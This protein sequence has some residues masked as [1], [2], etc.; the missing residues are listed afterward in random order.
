MVRSH[1]HELFAGPRPRTTCDRCHAQ[2]LRCVKSDDQPACL[3]C[4]KHSTS[5]TFSV[6]TKRKTRDAKSALTGTTSPMPSPSPLL[7]QGSELSL[8]DLPGM[9]LSLGQ[10][11]WAMDLGNLFAA[12][13]LDHMS[14]GSSIEA[15]N[16]QCSATL[17]IVRE[18]GTMNVRLYDH[19]CTLP[20]P[21]HHANDSHSTP[22]PSSPGS[23]AV[24]E[25][26]TLTNTFIML[27]R[28]LQVSLN[29][30][31]NAGA[32]MDQATTFLILSC[33]HRLMDIHGFIATSIQGCSQNP[34]MPLPGEQPLVTLPPMQVGS[35]TPAQLQRNGTERPASLSTVS[36]HMMVVL[37]LSSQLC[38]QLHEIITSGLEQ[39]NGE[40]TFG[41]G[42]TAI[43]TNSH[44]SDMLIHRSPL[45]FN[46]QARM[47][48]DQRWNTL[49]GQFQAAKQAVVLCSAMSI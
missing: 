36:M 22:D 49:T 41:L 31:V 1:T 12:E 48:I 4:T 19:F 16:S 14:T 15:Q 45:V 18:L 23:F 25:T 11:A 9:P 3:R 26:F 39:Y 6:R 38:Q 30:P 27:L 40:H 24:D 35:Y 44:V 29:D 17:D 46:D 34:Q 33:F 47:D 10:D 20:A 37:T 21:S 28:Q 2:K 42:S 32:S 5:C 7:I 43:S 8:T 13:S